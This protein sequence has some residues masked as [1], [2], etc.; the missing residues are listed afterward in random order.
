MTKTNEA[1]NV[2]MEELLVI[3]D[4][5]SRLAGKLAAILAESKVAETPAVEEKAPAKKPAA[6]KKAPASK[7]KKEVAPEPEEVEEEEATE[8]VDLS[9]LDMSELKELAK[10][11]GI[12]IPAKAA[13]ARII[14]LIEAASAE[15]EDEDEAEEEEEVTESAT[16]VVVE[17]ENGD[18]VTIEL[19][20]MKIKELKD[21]AAE[22]DIKATGK[23]KDA[24]IKQ[25]LAGF[26]EMDAEEEPEEDEV[27]EAE[28]AEEESATVI[29][30]EDED[31]EE[32]TVDLEE[33]NLKQL[34][35]IASDFEI[36]LTEKKKPGIIEEILAAF[37]GEE[38]EADEPEEDDAEEEEEDVAD[39][40]GLNDMDLEELAEILEEHGLS[41]KGKKQALIA[42]IVKAVE[43]GTIDVEGE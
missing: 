25:I 29:T 38:E 19:N 9:S 37:N 40:L 43:D 18:E 6:G 17:D 42:R 21:F 41:T 31:G 4:A 32:V 7:T 13:K 11:Y 27:E 5:H 16:A 8:E 28:D 30:Y 35:T 36:E 26:A 33:L 39:Q 14:K 1:I 24:V 15:T 3:A 23:T 2:V 34:K 10:E 20:D 12:T 22:F